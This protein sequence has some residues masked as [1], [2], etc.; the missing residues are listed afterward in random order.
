MSIDTS[1]CASVDFIKNWFRLPPAAD[2]AISHRVMSDPTGSNSAED[3]LAM[4]IASV[5]VIPFEMAYCKAVIDASGSL[6]SISIIPS[7]SDNHDLSR[8]TPH[9]LQSRQRDACVEFVAD[10]VK[11]LADP[12]LAAD[13]E[14]IQLG[15]TRQAALPAIGKHLEKVLSRAHF[16]VQENLATVTHAFYNAG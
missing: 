9:V 16:A 6:A 4:S 3:T 11:R 14:P 13:A 2:N 15:A 7:R 5:S 12:S 1:V 8:R 10:D